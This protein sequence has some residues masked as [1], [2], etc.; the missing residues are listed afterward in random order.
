MADPTRIRPSGKQREPD[1]LPAE[2]LK[3]AQDLAAKTIDVVADHGAD[4]AG[5]LDATPLS[6]CT[7]TRAR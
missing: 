4:P 3:L 2:A 5:K 6:I 1:A 7:M